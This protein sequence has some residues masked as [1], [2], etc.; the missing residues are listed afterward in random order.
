MLLIPMATQHTVIDM[1]L[2]GFKVHIQIGGKHTLF[3]QLYV[4]A[5]CFPAAC[6]GPHA[7]LGK[8]HIVL[9]C[10]VFIKHSINLYTRQQTYEI[11]NL[12]YKENNE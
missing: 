9:Y 8:L 10:I 6:V 5:F 4:S 2:S 7:D 1:Q 11:Q 3:V 12:S